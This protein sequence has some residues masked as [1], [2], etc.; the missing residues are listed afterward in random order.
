MFI[1]LVLATE[2]LLKCLCLGKWHKHFFVLSLCPAEAV[3][4]GTTA[5]ECVSPVGRGKKELDKLNG[6]VHMEAAER[7]AEEGI[8]DWHGL[9]APNP[10]GHR[11]ASMDK[12]G[13]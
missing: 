5:H 13:F 2:V 8:Q 3:S 7:M 6:S 1:C 4:L 10:K 12:G 9:V 11:D